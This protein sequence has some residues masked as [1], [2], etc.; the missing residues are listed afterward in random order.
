MATKLLYL[1][2]KY[3]PGAVQWVNANIHWLVPLGIEA[4]NIIK[5]MF[6]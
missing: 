2:A 1:A 4:Y 3:G 5:R 6:G